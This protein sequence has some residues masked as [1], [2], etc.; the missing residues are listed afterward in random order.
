MLELG[1]GLVLKLDLIIMLRSNQ[2]VSQFT[3]IKLNRCNSLLT[4]SQIEHYS[5]KQTANTVI[6]SFDTSC[7]YLNKIQEFEKNLSAESK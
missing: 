3:G 6:R 2:T 4:D 5:G 1:L 7:S